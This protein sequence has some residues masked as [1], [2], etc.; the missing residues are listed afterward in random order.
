MSAKLQGQVEIERGDGLAIEV[1][2]LKA[3]VEFLDKC[4]LALESL[5]PGGSEYFRDPERCVA[6][7]RETRESQRK[8]LVEAVCRAKELRSTINNIIE[9]IHGGSIKTVLWQGECGHHWIR[10]EHD[11]C[12][13][14]A[15]TSP[16]RDND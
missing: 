4:R 6:V 8:L 1:A 11:G 16:E 7:I 2:Q 5:T 10:A 14:C 9:A 13:V 3:E 15:A 12:P